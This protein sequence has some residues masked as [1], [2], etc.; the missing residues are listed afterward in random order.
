L[1]RV[2]LQTS[3]GGS[4]ALTGQLNG[5]ARIYRIGS[6]QRVFC[7]VF[8]ALSVFFLIVFWGG[9]ISGRREATWLELMIPIGFLVG[10]SFLSARAFKNY[11]GLSVGEI[12]IQTILDRQTLPF[13][14]I[15]GRRRYLSRGDDEFPSIWYLKLEP[16][17]DRFPTIEF[18]ESYYTLDDR[19]FTW[20]NALPDLDALD[21]LRA[22]T[23]NFG[24]V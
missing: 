20:F 9:A 5:T 21:K 11:I 15:R 22:K 6:G 7:I 19:F 23:S 4:A 14:K 8:M 18:E 17:D 1:E 16:N 10:G 3:S 12:R 24:H 2:I 13:D